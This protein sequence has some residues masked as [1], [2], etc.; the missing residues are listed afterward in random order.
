[1][2][3]NKMTNDMKNK[4]NQFIKHK[5]QLEAE[6]EEIKNLFTS[7]FTALNTLSSEELSELFVNV[8]YIVGSDIIKDLNKIL[9]EKEIEEHPEYAKARHIPELREIDFLPDS[10]VKLLDSILSKYFI[11]GSFLNRYSSGINLGEKEFEKLMDF[12]IKKGYVKKQYIIEC[13][14]SEIKEMISDDRYKKIESGC[15]ETD[16]DDFYFFCDEC[17]DDICIDSVESFKKFKDRFHPIYRVVK[18]FPYRGI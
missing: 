2:E 4:V 17:N 13:R 1:M 10:E 5:K 6:R 14:C 12:L 18:D 16:E 15:F 3:V 11:M 8:K 9:E 7:N